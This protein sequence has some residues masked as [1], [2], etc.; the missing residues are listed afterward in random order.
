MIEKFS[1]AKINL[2][3]HVRGRR[4]DGFH[5]LETLMVPLDVGDDLT[6]ERSGGDIDL[7]I[8]GADLDAGPDNLV[9]RAADLVR[10]EAGIREG[11]AI[12]LKKRLP[13]GGGLAGG[14][15]NAAVTLEACNQLWDAGLRP[16]DLHR[17]AATL[18][19]DIN[20]F[21]EH[22]PAL[23]RGR[24]EVVCPV[25]LDLDGRVLIVN[26]GFE[27]STPSVFRAFA[28]LSEDQKRGW[29]GRFILRG[30]EGVDGIPLRNDLEPAVFPK[31]LWLAETKAFLAG[32]DGVEDA[33]M[34][35][36]GASLFALLRSD[37]DE[38]AVMARVR[39][40]TGPE[41]WLRL[42]SIQG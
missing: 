31:Y 8:E 11:V 2:F 18:G 34:S 9:W 17:L 13:L 16:M 41:A 39:E 3:L 24:G 22:G 37:A 42:A 14:S 15:S 23:C 7:T 20:F 28:A 1:P 33:L 26:P 6:F 29:P 25:H 38:E 19:S 40:W 12:S 21:L 5:E 27:V 32:L 35:G 36:S 30:G 4:D 10:R